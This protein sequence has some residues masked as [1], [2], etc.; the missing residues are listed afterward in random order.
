MKEILEIILS[1]ILGASSMYL[2]FNHK[3][4]KNNIKIKGNQN[5][6][7]SEIKDNEK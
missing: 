1:Y 4:N 6:V 3:S 5:K 2:Y 7:V